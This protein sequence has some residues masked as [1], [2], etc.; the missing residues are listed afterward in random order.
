[1]RA[2]PDAEF[3]NTLP[4][5]PV[6]LIMHTAH[7]RMEF[8]ILA[9]GGLAIFIRTDFS[10]LVGFPPCRQSLAFSFLAI[11]GLPCSFRMPRLI[12]KLYTRL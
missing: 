11:L 12:G 2:E 9:T 6:T 5:P 7:A 8:R 1:M 4:C 3:F 10:V